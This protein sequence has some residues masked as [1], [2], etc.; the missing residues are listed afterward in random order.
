[1]AKRKRRLNV[2]DE[3]TP[4]S[5]ETRYRPKLLSPAVPYRRAGEEGA[6]WELAAR[7]AKHTIGWFDDLRVTLYFCGS[8]V[9]GWAKVSFY[10]PLGVLGTRSAV[11][12]EPR[13]SVTSTIKMEWNTPAQEGDLPDGT[14]V[15]AVRDHREIN[16]SQHGAS[17]KVPVAY[18]LPLLTSKNPEGS[19]DIKDAR[20]DLGHRTVGEVDISELQ[21]DGSVK[22]Y[23]PYTI[24]ARVPMLVPSGDYSIPFVLNYLSGGQVKSST[25]RLEFHVKSYWEKAWF[26][27]LVVASAVGAAAIATAEWF[28]LLR[29]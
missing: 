12:E 28:G 14:P 25:Y 21:P 24:C 18:F 1:M 6:H 7:V 11:D 3:G 22:R 17:L 23:E 29:A 26:Q 10:P 5:E 8:G 19:Q 20:V 15:R 9:P 2:P 27:A 13:I 4:A 16:V